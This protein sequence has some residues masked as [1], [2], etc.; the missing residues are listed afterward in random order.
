MSD[1]PTTPNLADLLRMAGENLHDGMF[2]SLPAKVTRYDEARQAVD[3]Q[4]WVKREV[5]LGDGS[6]SVERFPVVT[7][8]PVMFPRSGPYGITWPIAVGSVVLLVFPS[9]SIDRWL[10]TGGEVAPADG[11]KHT[12]SDAFAIPGGHAFA[13]EAKPPT[14]APTDAMVL[15]A[16]HLK[17]GG[18]NAANIPAIN[19]ELAALISVF[20]AH[21]HPD[22]VS[23]F[24][25]T[26]TAAASAPTGSPTIKVP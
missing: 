4:P 23:G 2:T 15:H 1:E 24:T 9:S 14:S 6:T 10:A 19:A 7:N 8:A 22:P 13:G 21:A 20:N 12:L 5:T 3:A 11:R 25:G 16:A 18:P 26:P 17:L